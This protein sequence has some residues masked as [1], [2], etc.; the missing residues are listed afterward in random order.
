MI[1][2]SSTFGIEKTPSLDVIYENLVQVFDENIHGFFEFK[3]ENE[4]INEDLLVRNNELKNEDDISNVFDSFL[5]FE[6]P[7]NE[8]KF[9]FKFQYKTIESNT[10]TDIGVISLRYS[11]HKCICFIEAKRLP[12]PVY[13][14]SQE[15]EYVCYKNVTKQGGIERFKTCKHGNKL[16]FSIMV[17]YIQ[18][19]NSSHWYKKINEWIDGQISKSSNKEITWLEEDKLVKETSFSNSKI[20]KYNSTH[21]KKNFTKIR[22][23]HYW[24]ELKNN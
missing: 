22:L 8:N 5:N 14:G 23:A 15:T 3:N 11:K 6:I 7:K 21:S 1:R 18:Q 17:G 10:S 24:F 2:N 19:E 13:S 16:P 12:T 20:T 4:K 9:H